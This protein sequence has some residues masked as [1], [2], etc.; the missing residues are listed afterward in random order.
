M[1]DH[2]VDPVASIERSATADDERH[3]VIDEV[4]LGELIEDLSV[5]VEDS[6][7]EYDEETTS[8][9]EDDEVDDEMRAKIEYKKKMKKREQKRQ[10]HLKL[11]GHFKD[12]EDEKRQSSKPILSAEVEA[13]E[14]NEGEEGEEGEEGDEIGDLG[15]GAEGDELDVKSI[16]SSSDDDDYSRRVCAVSFKGDFFQNFLFPSLS[17]I[18]T[19]SEE[20][21]ESARPTLEEKEA[22]KEKKLSEPETGQFVDAAGVD[23]RPTFMAEE[24]HVREA[25]QDL[26]EVSEETSSSSI[27]FDWPFPLEDEPPVAPAIDATEFALGMLIEMD[28]TLRIVPAVS[29]GELETVRIELANRQICIDLLYR[30][31]D[32][33][34]ETAEYVNPLKLLLSRLDKP[35]LLSDLHNVISECFAAKQFNS[36]LTNKMFDYYRRVGQLRCFDPLLSQQE[37]KEYKRHREALAVLDHL[38]KKAAETKANYVWLMASVIMDLNYVRKISLTTVDSLENCFRT[39]LLRKDF[40]VMPRIVE[41]ELRRM[42][43]LRNEISDSRLGLITRQHTLGRLIEVS[44]IYLSKGLS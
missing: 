31:I 8:I 14:L 41:H 44:A 17:D 27:S 30:I 5:D 12:M 18:T 39:T 6:K 38:K 28:S 13:D 33:V 26:E 36:D 40:E 1:G 21:A 32:D 25:Q 42:Q 34:V 20:V 16:I 10:A 24:E 15:E 22:D 29:T 4:P 7:P 9:M 19:E 11:R 43:S 37:L 3:I 23:Q 2:A 35:K